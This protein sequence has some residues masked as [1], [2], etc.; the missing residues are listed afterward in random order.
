MQLRRGNL[1]YGN[2]PALSCHSEER[3]LH[4]TWESLSRPVIL[5]GTAWSEESVR[6][7]FLCLVYPN[8]ILHFVQNDTQQ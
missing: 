8:R 1:G 7:Y 3:A 6:N 5:S 4:A 2:M